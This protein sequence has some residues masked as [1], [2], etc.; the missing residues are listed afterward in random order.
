VVLEK[1]GD[2]HL[3]QKW[4]GVT[5][6]QGGEDYPHLIK[7]RKASVIFHTFRRNCLLR[8]VIEG[9]IEG[10]M[11]VTGRQEIRSKQ[12]LDNLQE[13]RR[14][15]KLKEDAL[16]GTL[17][18]TR[19]GCAFGPVVRRSKWRWRDRVDRSRQYFVS[20]MEMYYAHPILRLWWEGVVGGLR[21]AHQAEEKFIQSVDWTS[22]KQE[23]T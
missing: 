20:V 14:C 12:I 18:R 16:D 9:K 6:S 21:V 13:T 7:R 10:R 4:G 3:Y 1:D 15:W 23:T 22:W 8:H 5:E 2:D 17:W 11:E 19:F